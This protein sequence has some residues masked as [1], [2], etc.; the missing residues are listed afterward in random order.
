ML[1]DYIKGHCY[2]LGQNCMFHVCTLYLLVV[3]WAGHNCVP[4]ALA[5]ASHSEG[6]CCSINNNLSNSLQ[7][8]KK[9]EESGSPGQV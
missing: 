6:M 1:F 7:L 2:A 4:A 3:S 8:A 9:Q 5:I